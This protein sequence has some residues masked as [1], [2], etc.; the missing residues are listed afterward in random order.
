MVSMNI[1]LFCDVSISLFVTLLC[2]HA[3]VK[4]MSESV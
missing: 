4:I 2:M 1:K 3:A